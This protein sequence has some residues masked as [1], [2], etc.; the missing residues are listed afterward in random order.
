MKA[1]VCPALVVLAQVTPGTKAVDHNALAALMP[2]VAGWTR[3]EVTGDRDEVMGISFRAPRRSTR[4]ATSRCASKSS[5]PP[6]FRW[7]G[8]PR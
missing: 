3:A 8:S 1:P 4:R 5:T 6:R 2:P 7:R